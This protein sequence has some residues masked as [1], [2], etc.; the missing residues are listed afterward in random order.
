MINFKKIFIP[1]LLMLAAY[2]PATA[3][4]HQ[5]QPAF[6]IKLPDANGEQIA[7]SSLK[8]K[9]VLIDFW[10]SWCGPC[11]ASNKKLTKIYDK[12]KDKGFEIYGISLDENAGAWQQAVK[13]DKVTW[14]QV[15][16]ARAVDSPIV[17]QWY[18]SS[19]PT[20]YLV[21]REGNV[22]AMD[23]EGKELVRLLEE[24]L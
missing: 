3:Q 22:V 10:A 6:E 18:I 7:L 4:V 8:G 11:R 12:Y 9:V 20:S 13:K 2:L 16:D 5:G 17:Q 1:C 14:L 15:N 24:L 23:P 19:I 21:D